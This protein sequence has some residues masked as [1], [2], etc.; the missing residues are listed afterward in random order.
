MRIAGC[1]L[2][3]TGPMMI[4]GPVRVA[5]GGPGPGAGSVRV[6]GAGGGVLVGGGHE[7]SWE[8]RREFM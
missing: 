7:S 2:R 3:V 5:G 4:A 1:F 8:I 6:L